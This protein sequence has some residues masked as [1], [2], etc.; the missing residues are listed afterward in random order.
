MRCIMKITY[1]N[2][3]KV[4]NFEMIIKIALN[5]VSFNLLF[6]CLEWI[7]MMIRNSHHFNQLIATIVKNCLFYV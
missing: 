3:M 7:T 2:A 4:I 1:D 5:G 6:D